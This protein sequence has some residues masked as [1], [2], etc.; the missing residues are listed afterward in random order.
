MLERGYVG[1]FRKIYIIGKVKSYK[2]NTLEE[3][4]LERRYI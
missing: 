4:T 2:T 1:G 3:R